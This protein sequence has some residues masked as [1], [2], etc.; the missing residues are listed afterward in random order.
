MKAVY[1][2]E[3]QHFFSSLIGYI[4]MAVF[5]ISSGLFLWVF[6]ES[7]LLDAGYAS[8]DYFFFLAPYIL[9]FLIPAITLRSFSEEM[10][11]GTI[12][13]LS[14]KPLTHLHILL[15]KYFASLTLVIIALLPTLIY[16]Y[17]IYRL[18]SPIG[19]VDMGGTLGSYFGLIMLS[20][21]FCAIGIFCSSVTSNQI[22]AFVAGL[23]LCFFLFESFESLSKLGILFAKNDYLVEQLGLRAHYASMSRGVIDSRDLIYFFSVIFLF[24]LFTRT[25]LASRKW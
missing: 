19:N 11:M 24:L 25:S 12:E 1:I 21:V 9:I 4:S 23:F 18:A 6:P 20:A 16:W 8:M 15:G 14:T 5:L 10:N 2:K 17:T 7:S 22:V 3:L 13:L